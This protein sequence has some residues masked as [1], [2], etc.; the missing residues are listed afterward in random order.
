MNKQEFGQQI[1]ELNNRLITMQ[2]RSFEMLAQLTEE[3]DTAR[4]ATKQLEG[5][6]NQFVSTIGLEGPTT[7]DDILQNLNELVALRPTPKKKAVKRAD[8]TEGK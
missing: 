1:Q 8:T 6:V 2:S 3:R 4:V 7:V 5:A